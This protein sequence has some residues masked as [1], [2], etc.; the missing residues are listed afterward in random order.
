MI[1]L[2]KSRRGKTDACFVMGVLTAHMFIETISCM[3]AG[4]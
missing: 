3:S 4:V 2:S 1:S